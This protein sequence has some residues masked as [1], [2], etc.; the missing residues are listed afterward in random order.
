MPDGMISNPC[1][2]HLNYSSFIIHFSLFIKIKNAPGILQGRK[3]TRYHLVSQKPCGA[4]AF[5]DAVTGATREW[6]LIDIPAPGPCSPP[7]PCPLSASGLSVRYQTV[8]LPF[9]AFC[10]I[11]PTHI[12]I[13]VGICQPLFPATPSTT[14]STGHSGHSREAHSPAVSRTSSPFFTPM[15]SRAVRSCAP[16]LTCT[17]RFS[18]AP[19]TLRCSSTVPNTVPRIMTDPTFRG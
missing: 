13:N 19:L 5:L 15:G 18:S 17:N 16:H 14:A 8:T 2:A 6:L 10:G 1:G 12:A 3:F 11:V 7:L 9:I 4:S